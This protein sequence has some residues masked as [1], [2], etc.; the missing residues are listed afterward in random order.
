MDQ[1]EY[2]MRHGL[3]R[4]LSEMWIVREFSKEQREEMITP[5]IE[6]GQKTKVVNCK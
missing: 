4:V 6:E 3:R 2:K 1:T 5:V